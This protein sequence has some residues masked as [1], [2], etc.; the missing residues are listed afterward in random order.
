ML[1]AHTCNPNY[2]GGRDQE[3]LGWKPP[4]ANSLQDPISKIP[5]TKKRTG[6]VA[7]VVE[8]LHSKHE[9]LR[10]NPKKRDGG[11]V[12]AV[13]H[14]SSKCKGLVQ[15]LVLIKKKKLQK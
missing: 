6:G 2:S 1:V 4:Q 13:E 14:L 5:N 10:S 9:A 12:Q 3:D 7:Q 11:V 15:T 8:R